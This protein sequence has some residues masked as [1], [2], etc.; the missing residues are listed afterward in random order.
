MGVTHVQTTVEFLYLVLML[1]WEQSAP[2]V[3]HQGRLDGEQTRNTQITRMAYVLRK[4]AAGNDDAFY[5]LLASH[6]RRNDG[7]S[8]VSKDA[9]WMIEPYPLSKGWYFEG[10]TSLIQKQSFLQCLAKAPLSTTF[11]ACVQDFVGAISVQE[12]VPS[13]QELKEMMN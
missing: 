12:Y 9:S 10:C 1:R 3:G 8:Y 5:A 13:E 4:I 2:S 11:V 6:T 7:K